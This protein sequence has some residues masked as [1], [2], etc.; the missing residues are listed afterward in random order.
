MERLSVNDNPAALALSSH[1]RPEMSDLFTGQFKT[2]P[3][4]VGCPAKPW[5]LHQSAAGNL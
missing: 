5:I 4:Q 1:C 3:F 2:K